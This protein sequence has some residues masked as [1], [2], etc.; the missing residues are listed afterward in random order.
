M[1]S[2]CDSLG[3]S[4]LVS[5]MQPGS[6]LFCSGSHL[7]HDT[8]VVVGVCLI[9]HTETICG[10]GTRRCVLHQ[11]MRSRPGQHLKPKTGAPGSRSLCLWGITAKSSLLGCMLRA[12]TVMASYQHG[13]GSFLKSAFSWNR[14]VHPKCRWGE[15]LFKNLLLEFRFLSLPGK[16]E[17][18]LGELQ[19]EVPGSPSPS[20]PMTQETRPDFA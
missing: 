13:T 1:L 6:T 9:K 2:V 5:A 4:W 20:T 18:T 19:W 8:K 3:S 15:N 11:L 12:H 7:S 14:E 16:T 10:R 17:R